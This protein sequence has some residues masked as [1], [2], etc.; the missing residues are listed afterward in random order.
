MICYNL[1]KSYLSCRTQYTNFQQTESDK[2]LVEYGVPQGSVLGPLLFLIYINDI[3]NSSELG[4]F[5][6]FADDTNIFCSGKTKDDAYK[7]ANKVLNDVNK[8]MRTNLLHI[9]MGKSVRNIM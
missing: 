8:Y 1:L 5:V 2:C 3:V 6:L 9:N 4:H 7:N